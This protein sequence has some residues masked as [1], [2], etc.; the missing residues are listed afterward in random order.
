MIVGEV[1]RWCWPCWE[2]RFALAAPQ[3]D[4]VPGRADPPY[5]FAASA[6]CSTEHPDR[7]A[8][9]REGR[10]CSPRPWSWHWAATPPNSCHWPQGRCC[11]RF[12]AGMRNTPIRGCMG[13]LTGSCDM[14][15]KGTKPQAGL[16]TGTGVVPHRRRPRWEAERA[17]TVVRH[18]E[19]TDDGSAQT[20]QLTMGSPPRRAGT[21][22]RRGGS[23]PPYRPPFRHRRSRGDGPSLQAVPDRSSPGRDEYP[24][25]LHPG[26]RLPGCQRLLVRGGPVLP[27]VERPGETGRVRDVLPVCDGHREVQARQDAAQDARRLSVAHRLSTADRGGVGGV[28]LSAGRGPASRMACPTI[29][30]SITPGMSATRWRGHGRWDRRSR[31]ISACS[32]CTAT[33]PSGA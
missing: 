25:G 17:T 27:L 33:S 21:R 13:H 10:Q 6:R 2:P 15:T 20:Q 1:R 18:A 26:G 19:R 32:T 3:T 31:T 12:S 16:G 11:R 22:H 7:T 9:G 8:Q 5:P 23:S 24:V 29:C 28:R 4:A 14:D 30:C